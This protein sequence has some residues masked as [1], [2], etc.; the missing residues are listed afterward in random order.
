MSCSRPGRTGEVHSGQPSGAHTTWML[1]PW[2][3]CFF[4]HHR[5]TPGVGPGVAIGSVSISSVEQ[6]VVVAGG[7]RGQ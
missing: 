5:S 3:L 1:P 7:L 4:D 6:D 2:F